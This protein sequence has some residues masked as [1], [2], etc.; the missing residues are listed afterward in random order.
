MLFFLSLISGCASGETLDQVS[1]SYSEIQ[2]VDGNHSELQDIVSSNVR[3]AGYNSDSK[4]MTVVF[5][6]GSRYEYFQVPQEL[7]NEFLE[8]QPNPWS[9]VGYPRLVGEGY[10]Y[11]RI[12]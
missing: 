8:A 12:N 11:K 1:E 7:W 10:Q 5:D 3:Q 4:V 2:M 6:N 9:R